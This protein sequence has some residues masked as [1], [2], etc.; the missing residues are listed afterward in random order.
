MEMVRVEFTEHVRDYL[1][2][3]LTIEGNGFVTSKFSPK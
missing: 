1:S 3:C 2:V